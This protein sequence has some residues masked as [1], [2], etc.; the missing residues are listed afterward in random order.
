MTLPSFDEAERR[1]VGRLERQRAVT[2]F[3]TRTRVLRLVGLAVAV[4]VTIWVVVP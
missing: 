3:R 1:R 2:R 4:L